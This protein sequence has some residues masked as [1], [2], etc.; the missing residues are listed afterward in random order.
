MSSVTI[1]GVTYSG[2]NVVITN[3]KV[4]IDGVNNTPNDKV[5]NITVT[6]DINELS[7]DACE[8]VAIVGNIGGS[9]KTVSGDIS[10]DGNVTGDIKTVSG[11]VKS[12]DVGGKITT[13][14]GD[15]K[16]RKVGT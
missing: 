10:I 14:S 1:N 9:V 16:H 5:I 2:R 11:D 12:N 3:G 8:L 4:M 6:G 15:V 7:V 13:V